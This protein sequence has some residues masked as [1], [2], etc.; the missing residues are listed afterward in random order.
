MRTKQRRVLDTDPAANQN[1]FAFGGRGRIAMKQWI[2]AALLAA[3]IG[4]AF[5]A[6]SGMSA[7]AGDN[8]CY[9]ADSP[10]TPP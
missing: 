6:Y 7:V 1:I 2:L 5:I 3:G 10:V 9:R 8:G 4:A